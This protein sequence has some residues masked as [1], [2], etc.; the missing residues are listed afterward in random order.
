MVVNYGGG[1]TNKYPK[2]FKK[3]KF[4]INSSVNIFIRSSNRLFALSLFIKM[5]INTYHKHIIQ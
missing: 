1:I 2:M 3:F 5:N 4:T